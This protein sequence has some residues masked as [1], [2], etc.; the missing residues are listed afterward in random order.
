MDDHGFM[1]Y[2]DSVWY[3]TGTMADIPTRNKVA[4]FDLENT[5]IW[6]DA[7]LPY[8]RTTYDWVP[9]TNYDKLTKEL[10]S[11][12]RDGWTIALFSN[13]LE[14]NPRHTA[15]TLERIS[16]F[17]DIIKIEQPQ[18]NPFIYLA[19]RDDRNRKPQ[20]GMWNLFYS[21]TGII[22]SPAS[23]YCGDAIGPT[24]PNPLYQW[25]SHDT[26]FAEAIGL[27][28]Y[29]PDEI[30][31]VFEPTIDISAYNILFIMAADES[32][33]RDFIAELTE[34]YEVGRLDNLRAITNRNKKAVIVGERL[35]T[36]AG[37]AR[38][39]NFLSRNQLETAAFLLFTRPVKPFAANW[40]RIANVVTG[41]ANALDIHMRQHEYQRLVVGDV[42][43][44]L[45]RMN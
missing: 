16:N 12:I 13:R 10:G 29:T 9:T 37:R 24:D 45:I 4:A 39:R 44:P 19:I 27:A 3:R 2:G 11:L 23:F 18:F 38:L 35:A 31:G 40:H 42:T 17:V 1:L 36:T 20:I 33:Y 30:L 7:G 34:D 21:H 28:V 6:S 25:S 15:R 32:Q 22:P 43:V 14:D 26:D 5:L 8:T 41:Y